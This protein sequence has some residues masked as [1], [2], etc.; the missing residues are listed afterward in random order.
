[1]KVI[2]TGDVSLDVLSELVPELSPEIEL[3]V[4]RAQIELRS[5]D[6]PSWVTFLAQCDW[7]VQLLAVGA[8]LYGT[9]FVKEAAKDTW[10]HREKVFETL[11][12][13]SSAGIKKLAACIAKLREQLPNRTGINIGIPIPDDRFPSTYKLVGLTTED[14]EVEIVIFATHQ[15]AISSLVKSERLDQGRLLGSLRFESLDDGSLRVSWTDTY[16]MTN[17]TRTLPIAPPPPDV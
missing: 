5:V 8:G 9:E 12:A 4:Q 17:V 14:L 2:S 7:W 3:E 16:T 15:A 1:M 11:K 6:P 13:G 10:K